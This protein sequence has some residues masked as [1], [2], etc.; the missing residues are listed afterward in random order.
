MGQFHDRLN[1]TLPCCATGALRDACAAFLME[2]LAAEPR[3]AWTL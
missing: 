2:F 1:L 3:L